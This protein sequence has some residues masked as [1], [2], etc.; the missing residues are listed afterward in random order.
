VSAAAKILDRLERVKQTAPG[1][2]IACCPAHEDRSPSLSI[3]ELDDGRLLVHCFAGC[4]AVD[5]LT[6]VGLELQDLYPQRL[7]EHSY[8]ASRSRIPAAD[9]LALVD[10]EITVAALITADILARHTVSPEQWARLA[11]A[12][13]RIGKVRD[14]GRA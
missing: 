14:H 4:G 11:T 1:R 10:H 2:W 12:A 5:V 3:R 9:L 6:A 13:G 8:A 7:P